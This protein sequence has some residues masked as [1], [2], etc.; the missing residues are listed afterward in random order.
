MYVI[1]TNELIY[2]VY[3]SGCG[4]VIFN[5]GSNKLWKTVP[6]ELVLCA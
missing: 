2:I 4:N 6:T 1:V 5:F 3:V